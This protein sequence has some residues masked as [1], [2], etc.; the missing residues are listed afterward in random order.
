MIGRY[1]EPFFTTKETGTGLGLAIVN[2]IFKSHGATM[3]LGNHEEGAEV[4]VE[5]VK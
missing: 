4:V 2:T 5:F 1:V 3:T